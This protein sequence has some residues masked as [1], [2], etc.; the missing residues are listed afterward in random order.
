MTRPSANVQEGLFE[1]LLRLSNSPDLSDDEVRR[2]RQFAMHLIA[3]FSVLKAE[4]RAESDE[5][6]A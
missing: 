1:A 2:V 6:V 3:E 4:E 5:A